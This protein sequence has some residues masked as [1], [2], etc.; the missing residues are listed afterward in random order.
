ME[1]SAL[2]YPG[3]RSGACGKVVPIEDHHLIEL[4]R[5]DSSRKQPGHPCSD[6]SG[7]STDACGVHW[8]PVRSACKTTLGNVLHALQDVLLAW[9]LDFAQSDIDTLGSCL[10]RP[11]PKR[12]IAGLHLL[13]RRESGRTLYP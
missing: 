7:S 2:R 10:E 8:G 5:K 9:S 12:R 3:P 6:D 4:G 13:R 1:V 11:G